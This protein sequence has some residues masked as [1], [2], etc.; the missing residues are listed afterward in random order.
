MPSARS[1]LPA[2]QKLTEHQHAQ[3]RLHLRELFARDPD[4]FGKFSLELD[5]MLLD[6]SKQRVSSE[7]MRLLAELARACELEDWRARML[8]G[9]H[10]NGSEDRAALHVALRAG[11]PLH[12]DGR[13]ITRDV[14]AALAEMR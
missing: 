12:V 11:A 13:D 2:W 8:A 5:G 14:A 3:S 9:E 10:V 6:Y 4:R 1:A 7:T